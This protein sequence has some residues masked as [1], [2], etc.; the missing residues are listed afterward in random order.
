MKNKDRISLLEKA[1][2][3]QARTIEEQNFILTLA[4]EVASRIFDRIDALESKVADLEPKGKKFE[5]K[6]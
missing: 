3:D 2:E 1:V 4:A 5:K 6:V